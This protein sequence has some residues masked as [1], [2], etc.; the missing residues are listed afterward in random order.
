MPQSTFFFFFSFFGL[1][2]S[3]S[4]VWLAKKRCKDIFF[5]TLHPL[6]PVIF[7]T[8]TVVAFVLL[9]NS[10]FNFHYYTQREATPTQKLFPE[11][12]LRPLAKDYKRHSVLQN[13]FT[14]LPNTECTQ[15]TMQTTD[16]YPLSP[17]VLCTSQLRFP[18][19]EVP[20]G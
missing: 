6:S 2:K 12:T 9:H 11:V 16:V 8:A 19:R 3:R 1:T 17:V 14:E 15:S 10:R 4:S 5:P 20:S 7:E 18:F 13:S